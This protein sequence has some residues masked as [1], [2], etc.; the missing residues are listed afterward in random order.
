[1]VGV[2]AHKIYVAM[3]EAENG[4]N[5]P[6]LLAKWSHSE[7]LDQLFVYISF[8][9]N[10]LFCMDLLFEDEESRISIRSLSS[11][12]GLSYL[13]RKMTGRGILAVRVGST[14]SWR[15]RTQQKYQKVNISNDEK[16]FGHRFDGKFHGM[17]K[18]SANM[19]Q[20]CYFTWKHDYDDKLKEDLSIG[21]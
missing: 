15:Q 13:Q 11:F 10:K 9:Q 21:G 19:S 8:F 1:V 17:I 3:W 6:K 18:A 7:F 20:Y 12:D 5:T 4:K 14:T 16:V 2:D